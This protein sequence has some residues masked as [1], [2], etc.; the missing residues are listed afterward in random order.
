MIGNAAPADELHCITLPVTGSLYNGAW[1][2]AERSAVH[3]TAKGKAFIDSSITCLVDLRRSG[4]ASA[5]AGINAALRL[6]AVCPVV[7]APALGDLKPASL[8]SERF[9]KCLNDG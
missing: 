2:Q 9:A 1:M 4:T 5:A 6:R 7:A 3:A 8:V